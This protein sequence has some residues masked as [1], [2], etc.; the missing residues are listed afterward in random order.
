M[1]QVLRRGAVASMLFFLCSYFL[2]AQDLANNWKVI[3]PSSPL[4][5]TSVTEKDHGVVVFAFTNVSQK[6]IAAYA[7]RNEVLNFET[8]Y[9]NQL[10]GFVPGSTDEVPFPVEDLKAGAGRD[11]EV[12]VVFEDGSSVGSAP[13]VSFLRGRAT[14]DAAELAR[15]REVFDGQAASHPGGIDAEAL[16]RGIGPPP[17]SPTQALRV[18]G[19]IGAPIPLAATL[20][21]DAPDFQRGFVRGVSITRQQA[22]LKVGEL[23]RVSAD[24]E[25]R[26][27][28]AP[29]GRKHLTPADLLRDTQEEYRAMATRYGYFISQAQMGRYQ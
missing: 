16:R 7:V 15:I 29:P 10:R 18:L 1:H 3:T 6:T 9:G 2:S 27:A 28:T 25:R 4:Q 17:K 5:V 24:V 22:L 19:S 23:E 14:G 11:L 13:L 8:D 21:H 20:R 12:S 26:L